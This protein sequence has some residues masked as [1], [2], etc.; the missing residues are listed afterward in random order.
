MKHFFALI[1]LIALF[2]SCVT[3]K[4]CKEKYPF[5]LITRIKDTTI[6]TSSKSFD[7]IVSFGSR[8]TIFIRDLKTKI[9]TKVLRINDSIYVNTKCPSD[10]IRVEK[11]IQSV[12]NNAKKE[13]DLWPVLIAIIATVAVFLAYSLFIRLR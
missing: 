2:D 11:V 7:T 5:E 6:V 13:T 10:T 12:I 1:L 4:K 9:E 3:E 8:D